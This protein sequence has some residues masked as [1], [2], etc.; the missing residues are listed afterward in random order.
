MAD[1][2]SVDGKFT[3]TEI[4]VINLPLLRNCLQTT[5]YK[6]VSLVVI[7]RNEFLE[8]KLKCFASGGRRRTLKILY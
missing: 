7:M 8:K 6:T 1:R 5:I 2:M 3:K 4:Y